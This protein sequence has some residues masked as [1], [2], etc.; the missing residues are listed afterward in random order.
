MKQYGVTPIR[1]VTANEARDKVVKEVRH[2]KG[3][4]IKAKLAIAK[5]H[6]TGNEEE[7]ILQNTSIS[8][9]YGGS[10]RA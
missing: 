10:L 8:F 5:G 6:V 3:C 2:S 1:A 4:A 9:A 7:L